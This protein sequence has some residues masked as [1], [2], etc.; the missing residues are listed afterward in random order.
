MYYAFKY[1]K[2]YADDMANLVKY[3]KV[4]TK[5][6]G[7]TFSSQ[8][9]FKHGLESMMEMSMFEDGEVKRFFEDSFLQKKLQNSI[10]FGANIF[11]DLLLT[12]TDG[13]IEL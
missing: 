4:D 2:P 5:K 6:M 10:D 8:R 13:F 9:T 11:K 3:S 12:N 1:L 7:N